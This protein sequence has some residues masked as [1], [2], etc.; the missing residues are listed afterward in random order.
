MDLLGTNSEESHFHH[1]WLTDI[2]FLLKTCRIFEK[3]YGVVGFYVCA[4]HIERRVESKH[5]C[6]Y[7][8]EECL[9]RTTQN[10]I[11][12]FY[13]FI[14]ISHVIDLIDL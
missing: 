6:L 8:Y 2:V 3:G 9:Y 5:G 7:S 12:S 13:L 1:I 11:L 10:N 14:C 4:T